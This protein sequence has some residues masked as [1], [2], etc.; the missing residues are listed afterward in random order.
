MAFCLRRGALQARTGVPNVTNC[1]GFEQAARTTA[2]HPAGDWRGFGDA[3]RMAWRLLNRASE[4]AQPRCAP[5][6][7]Q[8][9]A[10]PPRT[11]FAC[12]VPSPV[13]ACAVRIRAAASAGHV[14]AG[15]D[16]SCERSASAAAARAVATCDA[17]F[18][19][20]GDCKRGQHTAAGAPAADDDGAGTQRRTAEARAVRDRGERCAAHAGVCPSEHG[21]HRNRRSARADHERRTRIAARCRRDDT[22]RRI[23]LRRTRSFRPRVFGSARRAPRLPATRR[24]ARLARRSPP[25]HPFRAPRQPRLH[26]TRAFKR[27]RHARRARAAARA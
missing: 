22:V 1:S 23:R 8:R 18:H 27:L 21:R 16:A 10:Y 24:A 14:V 15:G 11:R 17:S 2:V 20:R 13:P 9:L 4:R 3:A 19:G 26:R 25:A 6:R 7:R 5:P 12:D